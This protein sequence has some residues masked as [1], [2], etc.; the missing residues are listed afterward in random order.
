MGLKMKS[1]ALG[2]V[3]AVVGAMSSEGVAQSQPCDG[4]NG[5]PLTGGGTVAPPPC[6]KK[7]DVP[8]DWEVAV[9]V[10]MEDGLC[11]YVP[12][13]NG[14]IGDCETAPCR[15]AV[16]YAWG[17]N[18]ASGVK[19]IGYYRVTGAQRPHTELLFP[20]GDPWVPGEFGQVSFDYGNSPQLGCGNSMVFFMQG[21]MCGNYNVKVEVGCLNCFGSKLGD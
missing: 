18:A 3:L 9:S 21:N 2:L 13:E 10:T 20:E 17:E 5:K 11:E 6:M 7:G 14:A 15:T 8:S 1:L 12:G 19:K 4:C 16:D